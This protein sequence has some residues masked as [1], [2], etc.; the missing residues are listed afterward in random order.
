[1]PVEPMAAPSPAPSKDTSHIRMAAW[2]AVAAVAVSSGGISYS[3][4]AASMPNTAKTDPTTAIMRQL[5]SLQAQDT[6]IQTTL[7]NMQ[8]ELNDIRSFVMPE[9]AS[10]TDMDNA[11]SSHPLPPSHPT[12]AGHMGQY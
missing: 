7:D 4:S 5:S 1:M 3:A 6:H 12:S 8:H 10:G 2:L 9:D 11:T